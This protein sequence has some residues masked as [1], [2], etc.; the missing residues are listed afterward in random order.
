ML[1]FIL[2][3][4]AASLTDAQQALDAGNY[5]QAVELYRQHIAAE[6]EPGYEALYGLARSLAFAGRYPEALEAYNQ[7]LQRFPDDPD[8][9]VGR[10]RVYAWMQKPEAA[11]ADFQAVIRA[12]PENMDAWQAQADLYRW[13]AGTTA[14]SASSD[15]FYAAWQR[16]FPTRPEPL[17]A[18]ARDFM[19]RRQF[20]LAREA[21]SRARGLGADNGDADRLLAQINRQR[22]A[23]DWEAQLI[24]E[25]QAFQHTQV[26]WHTLNA[27]IGRY[28]DWGFL[29]VQGMATQRFGLWDQ[30][31]GT[32]DYFDLWPGAYG[33]V[34]LM[35]TIDPEVLPAWDLS[36][37]L[38]QSLADIFELSGGYRLMAFKAA[39]VHF[40]NLGL[41]AYL[42]N[43]YVGLQPMFFVSSAEGPGAQLGAW[44]RYIFN[45]ADDYVELRAG[46]GRRIAVIGIDAQ[47]QAQLQGQNTFYSALLGQYFVTPNIGLLA[48]I[49]YNFDEQFPS[50]YGVTVGSKVRW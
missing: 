33:N 10:G 13:N 12:H 4:M 35:G 14:D 30:A 44:G 2:A 32:D 23:L 16:Q 1:S 22:G 8:A 5:S 7:V 3:A 40:F 31:V 24:Y 28:F 43:W 6:S 41:G 47:N 39:N 19:D 38:Y 48:G 9:L 26:P 45:T 21:V 27:G 49:N 36:G 50:R 25:F 20:P 42:G 34:R 18:Q 17:L 15:E 11:T 46:F 29:S 37:Q